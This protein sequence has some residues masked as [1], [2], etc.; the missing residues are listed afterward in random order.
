M[1]ITAVTAAAAA[2]LDNGA[3]SDNLEDVTHTCVQ[4]GTTLTRTIRL[5]TG[6]AQTT[7]DRL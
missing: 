6:D 7:A 2:Q 5:L 1:V 4:C 3:G